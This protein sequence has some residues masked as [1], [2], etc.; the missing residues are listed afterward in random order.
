MDNID[1]L[2]KELQEA[3]EELNKTTN[4]SYAGT[5]NQTGSQPVMQSE[6]PSPEQEDKKMRTVAQ[7][8]EDMGD[9]RATIGAPS[10]SAKTA[11]KQMRALATKSEDDVL[12]CGEYFSLFKNGQWSMRKADEPKTSPKASPKG[13]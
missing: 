13:L 5:S 1:K 6:E 12:K 8:T 10:P 4:Q 7:K 2:I 9:G 11:D 3:K